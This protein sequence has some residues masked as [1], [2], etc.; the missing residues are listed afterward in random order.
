MWVRDVNDRRT[1]TRSKC[2]TS[3]WCKHEPGFVSECEIGI[4]ITGLVFDTVEFLGLP[5]FYLIFVTLLQLLLWLLTTP[6]HPT[7]HG[8]LHGVIAKRQSKVLSD[9]LGNA[10]IGP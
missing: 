9:N 10:I 1:P 6:T 3:R 7:F 5:T 2:P 4:P 8:T